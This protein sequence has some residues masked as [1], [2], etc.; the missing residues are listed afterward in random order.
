MPKPT[1]EV[2]CGD[3]PEG[4]QSVC[5]TEDRKVAEESRARLKAEGKKVTLIDRKRAPH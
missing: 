5:R 4:K 1:Y 2:L 3:E